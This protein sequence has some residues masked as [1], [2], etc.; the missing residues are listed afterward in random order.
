MID[1]LF[2]EEVG[3]C[4]GKENDKPQ[5]NSVPTENT[6]IEFLYEIH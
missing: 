2:L 6:E 1:I 4:Q 3:D 5:E